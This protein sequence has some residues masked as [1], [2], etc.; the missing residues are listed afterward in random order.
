VANLQ[1]ALNAQSAQG[2]TEVEQQEKSG[3][4]KN[5]KSTTKK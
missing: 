1:K 3:K 4:T 5:S 2:Q